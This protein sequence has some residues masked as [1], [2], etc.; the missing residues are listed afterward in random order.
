L[1]DFYI[2]DMYMRYNKQKVLK[3]ENILESLKNIKLNS[4][5]LQ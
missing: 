1:L 3:K 5:E 4:M 2:E